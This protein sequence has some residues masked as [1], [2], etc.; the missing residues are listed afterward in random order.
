MAA[1]QPESEAAAPESP[2]LSTRVAAYGT[3]Y[4]AD[5]G[6]EVI[7]QLRMATQLWNKLVEIERAHEEAKDAIWLSV[8]AVK[9][10]AAALEDARAALSAAKERMLAARSQDRTTI[11]RREDASHLAQLRDG[12]ATCA[13]RL[14]AARKEASAALQPAFA[15][16]KAERATAIKATYPDFVQGRGLGWGTY[17]DIVRRRFPAAVAKVEERRKAGLPAQLRFRR[18][19]GTGT[20][21][22]QIQHQAGAPPRTLRALNSG[23]HPKSATLSMTPWRDPGE[24]RPEGAERHGLLRLAAGRGRGHGPLRLELPVVLDRY[25]DAAADIAEVKLSRRA[26]AGQYRWHVAIAYRLP[27]PGPRQSGVTLDVDFGWASGGTDVGL[28]VA[29]VSWGSQPPG[30]PPDGIAPLVVMGDCIEIWM[31][32]QWR[33]LAGRPD[34]IRADRDD[35]FNMIRDKASGVLSA[36][37]GVLA[38]VARSN[39]ESWAAAGREGEPP[40]I[41][42]ATVSRWRAPRRLAMLAGV[43][44]QEHPLAADLEAWRRRDRH[45]HEFEAHERAQIL[46]RRTDAYRKVAA[47][48]AGSAREI[49]IKDIDVAAIRRVPDVGG[50]DTFEA[51][52]S[53]RQI[54]FAAPGELRAAIESAAR[55]RGVHLTCRTE[56][57]KSGE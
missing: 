42:A 27:A 24:G 45:L 43:W 44:P 15:A 50:E 41:T 26:T 39:A 32:A 29:R 19:D 2:P 54:H 5:P 22:V 20:L 37:A 40:A 11:P 9:D 21:T 56:E 1:K 49:V 51:R 6:P 30:P 4:W 33:H 13:K 53:R 36:D 10:T 57:R 3:P 31:P 17:N 35:L 38:A 18:F 28:R 7:A 23:V 55:A 25:M 16:A 52:G 47:W 48:L 14:T 46:S 8:P 12:A 34:A